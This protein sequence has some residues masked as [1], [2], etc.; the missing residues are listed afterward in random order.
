MAKNKIAKNLLH[1]VAANELALL[2]QHFPLFTPF[3]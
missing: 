1:S 3:R 2:K